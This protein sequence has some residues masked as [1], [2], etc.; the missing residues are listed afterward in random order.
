MAFD[1]RGDADARAAGAGA[2]GDRAHAQR[3]GLAAR[4]CGLVPL[5]GLRL[6]RGPALRRGWPCRG[7]DLRV[8]YTGIPV[9]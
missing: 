3:D 9:L 1:W 5:R 6:L 7:R 2:C 8:G 4:P